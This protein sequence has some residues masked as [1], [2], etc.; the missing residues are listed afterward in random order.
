MPPKRA[1][2]KPRATSGQ[3][4]GS[5]GPE[6][7][8]DREFLAALRRF[9]RTKGEDYLRD[10]NISSIGIGYKITDGEQTPQI[11]VQFTVNEKRSAPEAMAA[12]GTTPIPASITIDG[13]QVPTDVLERQYEP[14]FQVVPEPIAVQRKARIDPVVPGISV[15][16]IHVSAGT[17]GAIVYDRADATPYVL[18]NWHVL[19][20]PD[21]ALG[22]DVVQPGPHDDNRTDRNRL[23]RLARSHLGIAGDCAIATIE[24][25]GFDA[26]ILE[27]EVVPEQL[28]EPELGDRVVKSGRTTGVTRG[29]VRRVDTIAKL[30]YGGTAGVQNIGC[31]EIGP[32]PTTPRPPRRSAAAATRGRCGCSPRTI[33]PTR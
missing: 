8:G 11:A 32:T 22:D 31:F 16:N 12:L 13:V 7:A 33:S 4:A 10:P 2:R 23:G 30:D 18:S 25:R 20:G 24:D 28:G 17:I 26:T 9:I 14:A 3:S 5:A 19:H 15:G 29:V 1:T 6:N 27:L 21:G